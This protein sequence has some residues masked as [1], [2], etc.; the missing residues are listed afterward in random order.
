MNWISSLFPRYRR[1]IQLAAIVILSLLLV[2]NNATVNGLVSQVVLS[3]FYYPFATV[4]NSIVELS[5][6]NE[7]NKRLRQALVEASVRLSSLEESNREN[8]RL[9]SVLGFEPPPGYSLMPAQVLSVSGERIP[10]SAT[11]NRGSTDSVYLDQPVINQQGLIGRV[12]AVMP[13]FA[14]VQLLTDPVNRV[15]VRVAD[16]R[17]MGI[18]RFTTRVGMILDNFPIQGDI[19]IND[20]IL[21]S[22]LGG[23]YPPGLLVGQVSRVER[24]AESPFCEVWIDAIANFNSLEEM[25]LLRPDTP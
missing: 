7:E 11:I 24:P 5:S 10:L 9:R 21:S 16:S 4:K 17:E 2:F 25:F 20:R 22:G 3:V 1:N 6:V 14:T 23:V 8:S 19:K 15:A 12:S 18:A 13:D